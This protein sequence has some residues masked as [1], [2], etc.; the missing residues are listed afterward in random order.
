[1]APPTISNGA[2]VQPFSEGETMKRFAV[3]GLTA[4]LVLASTAP[5]ARAQLVMQMGNGWNFSIAGN[6]NAFY[7]EQWSNA[8]APVATIDG[9]LVAQGQGTNA[10]IRT[11]LLPAAIGFDAKGK[12]GDVLIDVHFGFYPQ[13]QNG[14]CGAT[15]VGNTHDQFG[16]QID[17]R[18]VYLTV[19]SG[20]GQILAGREIELYQRQNIL[21]DAT[22]FGVGATGGN[23]GAGGTTLGRIG[24][25]YVYPNF[26]AQLTYSTPATSPLQ[27]SIG[28]FQPDNIGGG[29]YG[30]TPLPRLETEVSYTAKLGQSATDKAMLWVNGVWQQAQ[31]RPTG[32]DTGAVP[33]ADSTHKVNAVGVGA[34]IKLDVSR[35]SI[36]GSGYYGRGIGTV[37]L[38]NGA[39]L[40]T[41]AL[42]GNPDGAQTRPSYGYIGQV[43]LKLDPK[44][45]AVASWGESMGG[46]TNFD[47]ATFADGPL[48]KYNALGVGSLVYQATKSL[49]WVIEY[50]YTEAASQDHAKAVA[51]QA[52]TGFMV[53]F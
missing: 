30:F 4:F 52:A 12:E 50:D 14:G 29:A 48:L 25:G 23:L 49:K 6:V 32:L 22:L 38:F 43:S 37:T 13:I 11:G 1:M 27:W 7:V 31:D 19:S 34:G 28:V 3:L 2:K 45:T 42:D 15:C 8:R 9:G 41:S 24:F 53:F 10:N 20:W 17:M 21:T 33:V 51:N 35:L 46:V 39:G 18:Q 36:V 26:G 40:G 16:A 47:R 5:T 44:W